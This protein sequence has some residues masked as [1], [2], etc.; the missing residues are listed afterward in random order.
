[1]D[2]T[3]EFV[4]YAHGGSTVNSQLW[5]LEPL[6][7]WAKRS[8][9]RILCLDRHILLLNARIQE[10]EAREVQVEAPVMR[11]TI[12]SDT[13]GTQRQT[14]V[15]RSCSIVNFNENCWNI[16][17]FNY[18]HNYSCIQLHCRQREHHSGKKKKGCRHES[19]GWPLGLSYT[20]Y[21][22]ERG[23]HNRRKPARGTHLPRSHP[24]SV[25]SA[26]RSKKNNMSKSEK[27]RLFAECFANFREIE[28]EADE[29]LLPKTFKEFVTEHCHTAL[30]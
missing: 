18:K 24:W 15:T 19:C 9:E 4:D 28:N 2:S 13:C 27:V 10:L 22:L 12:G 21:A 14:Q 7:M 26:I 1:M 8:S 17:H 29:L 3:F 20:C 25:H 11:R 23:W 30:L 6:K 5:K 16:D